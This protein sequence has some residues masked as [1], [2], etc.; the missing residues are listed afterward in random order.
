MPVI[1]S[2]QWAGQA[3]ETYR[4]AGTV[5]LMYLAG[6]GIMAHPGGP[7]AGVAAIR[8]AWEAATQGIPL[9]VFGREH[10]ELRQAIEKYGGLK[11]G[12]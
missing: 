10:I 1:S 5:D 2:G 3:P 6:G 8:Q 9:E 4:R 12:S 7:G 11:G